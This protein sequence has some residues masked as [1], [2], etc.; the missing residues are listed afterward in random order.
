LRLDG[1]TEGKSRLGQTGSIG[2]NLPR[3]KMKKDESFGQWLDL[4]KISVSICPNNHGM[5][6]HAA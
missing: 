4:P 5:M 2:S 3:E 6:I 1:R